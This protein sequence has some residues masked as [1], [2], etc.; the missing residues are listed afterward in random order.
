MER[1]LTPVQQIFLCRKAIGFLFIK[2]VVC[3]SIIVSVLRGGD[4]EVQPRV[5]GRKTLPVRLNLP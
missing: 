3:C 4:A 2:P 1:E 5:V